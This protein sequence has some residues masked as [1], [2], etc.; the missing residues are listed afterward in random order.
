MVSLA[1]SWALDALQ[2]NDLEKVGSQ[3]RGVREK[4]PLFLYYLLSVRVVAEEVFFRGFL[5]RKWGIGASSVAFAL[6]HAFYGS[7]AEVL[8]AFVLGVLLAKAYT[9]YRN[10]LPN[11][12]A[13]LAYNLA[14]LKLLFWF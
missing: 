14:I 11:I 12:F 8:G 9:S 2:V 7:L 6:A 3:V 4:N 1:L 10:L 13:H 5:V